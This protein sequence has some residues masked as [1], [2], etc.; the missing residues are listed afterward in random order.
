MTR[1][2]YVYIYI[3]TCIYIYSHVFVT[4]KLKMVSPWP[5]PQGHRQG[6]WMTLQKSLYEC[7]PYCEY[8]LTIFT[9]CIQTDRP[10]QS[11]STQMRH[12]SSNNWE[13]FPKLLPFASSWPGAMINPKWLKQP[14][15][16][17]NFHGPK[18]VQAIES[19]L[20][21]DSPTGC[22]GGGGNLGVIVVRVFEPVFWNLPQSYLTWTLKK[23]THLYTRSSEMLTH[24][25]TA[26]WFLYPFIAGR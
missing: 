6:M 21:L 12:R 23:R 26:L 11:V 10:E 22:V 19:W 8:E 25:Y 18:D 2:G 9:I 4:R 5:W 14:I 20:H 17:A 3:Y 16:W 24:S 7:H 1:Q 15:S 13:E